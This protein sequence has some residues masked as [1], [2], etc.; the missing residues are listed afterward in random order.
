M[1]VCS[2]RDCEFGGLPQPLG[3][4]QVDNSKKSGYK[5]ACKACCRKADRIRRKKKKE[6]KRFDNPGFLRYISSSR[7]KRKAPCFG[8][9]YAS[10]VMQRKKLTDLKMYPLDKIKV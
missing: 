3:N 9:Q 2:K 6:A 10:Y 5:S 7:E 1:K 4:F 8:H